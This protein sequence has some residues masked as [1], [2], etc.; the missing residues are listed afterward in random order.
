MHDNYVFNWAVQYGQKASP[1]KEII[2]V[3]CF[4]PRIYHPEKSSTYFGTRK[5]GLMRARFQVETV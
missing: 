3:F 2:P 5:I 1:I 4:D